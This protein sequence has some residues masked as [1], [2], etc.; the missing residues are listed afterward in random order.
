MEYS[1]D[2]V[3]NIRVSEFNQRAQGIANWIQE[4]REKEEW[5]KDPN[6]YEMTNVFLLAGKYASEGINIDLEAIERIWNLRKGDFERCGI[7][8]NNFVYQICEQSYNAAIS[9]RALVSDE[10]S[11]SALR[12]MAGIG[13]YLMQQKRDKGQDID[14]NNFGELID[15]IDNAKELK[16]RHPMLHDE[17]K[18]GNNLNM[19]YRIQR[20]HLSE[21]SKTELDVMYDEYKSMQEK[22]NRE[23]QPP[24]GESR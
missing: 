1:R 12:K 22:E 2:F 7:Q 13:L 23:N 3:D 16:Q 20:T 4:N 21:Q 15:L 18:F 14:Y 8:T 6:A 5:A 24:S 11:H 9:R 17:L 19:L 10:K